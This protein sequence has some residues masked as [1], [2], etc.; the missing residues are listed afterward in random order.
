MFDWK[1]YI[2]LYPELVK[3]YNLKN[4]DTAYK[5]WIYNGRYEGRI[6]YHIDKDIFNWKEYLKNNKYL[7]KEGIRDKREAILHWYNVGKNLG[8][9]ISKSQGI[10]E[11][12]LRNMIEY[13]NFSKNLDIN[14]NKDYNIKNKQAKLIINN[15]SQ[16]IFSIKKISNL[17]NYSNEKKI[18]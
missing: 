7:I 10:K 1:F 3:K 17:K 9:Q 15:N 16:D 18:N 13:E 8:L 11:N 5:H 12:N 4:K 14:S 6:G 2:F